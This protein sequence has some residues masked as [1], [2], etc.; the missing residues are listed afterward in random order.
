MKLSELSKK[1]KD[2]IREEISVKAKVLGV[3]DEWYDSSS[4]IYSSVDLRLCTN[5]RNL[6]AYRLR[7]GTERA[8]CDILETV[9]NPGDPV[10]D[11]S[12]YCDRFL[13]SLQDMQQIAV[14]IDLD[15]KKVGF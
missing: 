1:D 8:Y 11:C 10:T 7:Y 6:R 2:I 15:T 14:L 5:C 4:R 13:M 12:E 3:Y 9:L